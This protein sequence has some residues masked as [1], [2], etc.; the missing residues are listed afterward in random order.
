MISKHLLRSQELISA[1]ER[2]KTRNEAIF[3]IAVYGSYIRGKKKPND[4]D[5]AIILEKGISENEKLLLS[6]E[7]RTFLEK[8]KT[9]INADVQ[10]V[11]FKDFV[12][13]TFMARQGIL[14]E[15]YLILHQKSLSELLGFKTFTLFIFSLQ[16]M[17]NSKKTIFSYALNG[18]RG[19]KGIRESL[20]CEHIGSGVIKVPVEFSEE[21]KLFL[22]THKI[23]Y[24]TETAM[25]YYF[26]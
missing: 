22:E 25:F 17:P 18:R 26:R 8:E 21:F 14:A 4:I 12:S 7:F 19:S 15:S 2:L 20:C 5:F 16:G 1:A 11:S 6:Q 23:K 13:Q 9:G 24:R 3:D 10:I